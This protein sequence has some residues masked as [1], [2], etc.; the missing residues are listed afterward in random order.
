MVQ[1]SA[2]RGASF[3]STR[4]AAIFSELV[5]RVPNSKNTAENYNIEHSVIVPDCHYCIGADLSTISK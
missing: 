1:S 4:C 2:A 3:S 5:V